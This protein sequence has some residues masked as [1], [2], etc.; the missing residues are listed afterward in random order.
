MEKQQSKPLVSFLR[1]QDFF[2]PDQFDHA[3]VDVVGCGGIGS[4][5][6]LGLA[7]L[8][9]RHIRVW[10]GDK[11]EPHNVP[12]QMHLCRAVGY[13]KVDS[14]AALAKK[15]ADTDITKVSRF[16]DGE[17][18]KGVVI[19]ALDHIRKTGKDKL[20]GREELWKH[21]K[22]NPNVQFF[23]DGR[24]G[25]EVVRVLTINPMRDVF[26]WPWYEA[27]LYP[28]GEISPAPC[29]A[30][31]IIDVGFSV[32]ALIVNLVRRFLTHETVPHD[33]LYDAHTLEIM[34]PV[35]EVK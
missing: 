25:G 33:I 2:D 4:F 18:L 27:L 35:V 10:D 7:K 30:R 22:T 15:L 11:V 19:S 20:A 26:L 6:V 12:N 8:G 29:T 34:K 24:L 14:I 9:I 23:I 31:S 17:P 5:V 3:I 1:Q 16:W 13:P 21:L 28:E 32:G